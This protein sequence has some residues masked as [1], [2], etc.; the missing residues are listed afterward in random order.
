M[1]KNMRP[2]TCKTHKSEDTSLDNPRI[3]FPVM[4]P[5]CALIC[6]NK[7]CSPATMTGR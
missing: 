4:L 1:A 2:L 6:L 3:F 5:V 7:L